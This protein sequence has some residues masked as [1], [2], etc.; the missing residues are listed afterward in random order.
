MAGD[1][2]CEPLPLLGKELSA[3]QRHRAAR[4]A[5]AH[6]RD[7]GDLAQLLD[8]LGLTAAEGLCDPAAVDDEPPPT[9]PSGLPAEV[10][11]E[12]AELR[13]SVDHA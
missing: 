4:M 11:A 5:A 1:P 3:R 13:R 7:A 9:D 2:L 6:A 10:L 8:M 12:M